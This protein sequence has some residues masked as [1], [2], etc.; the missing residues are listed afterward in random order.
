MVTSAAWPKMKVSKLNR[1]IRAN[2]E[3]IVRMHE[4]VRKS[5][6]Q[7]DQDIQGMKAWV[8]ASTEFKMRYD[9]LAFPG[10]YNGALERIS[11]GDPNTLEAALSFLEVRPYFF[12]SGYMFRDILRKI[13]RARLS[14]VQTERLQVVIQRQAEW[15]ELRNVSVT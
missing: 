13:K 7:R 8:N 6:K 10:G 9:A 3:E 4:R 5:Y 2:A 14:K 11:M 12:R 1:I 15:R